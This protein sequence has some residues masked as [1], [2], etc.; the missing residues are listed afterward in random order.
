VVKRNGLRLAVTVLQSVIA[1]K[2]NT[3]K[4]LNT[5]TVLA[6]LAIAV[7]CLLSAFTTRPGG[8]GYTVHLN[9]KLVG[10]YYLTSTH[11][12][13]TVAVQNADLKSNLGIYF[14][15]CGSIGAGRKLSVRSADQ[16]TL[17]EWSFSNSTTKH[18]AMEVSI[19]DVGSLL[20]SGKV[21]IYYTSERVTKPQLLIYLS[22]ETIAKGKSSSR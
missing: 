4:K 11:Q 20:S 19:Q 16:K 12:T 8:Y 1:I 18:D 9:N 7:I 3:M 13:P 6:G 14:N 2:S 17:K 22:T 21:A 5:Q 15:E 10:E